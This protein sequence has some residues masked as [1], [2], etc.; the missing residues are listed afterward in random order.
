MKYYTEK[1]IENEIYKEI[2]E[3]KD[4]ASES[5]FKTYFNWYYP[6]IRECLDMLAIFNNKSFSEIDN[7]FDRINEEIMSKIERCDQNV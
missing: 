6:Q 7:L 4:M 5:D 3:L 2:E 1:D